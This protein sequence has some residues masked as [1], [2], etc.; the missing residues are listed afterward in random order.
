MSCVLWWCGA[1]LTLHTALGSYVLLGNA[2]ETIFYAIQPSSYQPTPIPLSMENQQQKRMT[3]SSNRSAFKPENRKQIP[4]LLPQ[5]YEKEKLLRTVTPPVVRTKSPQN[6][7]VIGQPSVRKSYFVPSRMETGFRPM[8]MENGK[9]Y[10]TNNNYGR[11]GYT[12]F[13]NR[14]KQTWQSLPFIHEQSTSKKNKDV[15]YKRFQY[16]SALDNV[17]NQYFKEKPPIR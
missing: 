12:N 7:D 6:N 14:P 13:S 11:F 10:K 17:S 15:G 4:F 2:N 5:L 3:L 1:L 16:G 8:L 9:R